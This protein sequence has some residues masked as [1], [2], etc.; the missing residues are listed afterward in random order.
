MTL[1][2]AAF[3]QEV[4]ESEK[5]LSEPPFLQI[6]PQQLPHL[7]LIRLTLQTL[8]QLCCCCLDTSKS[9]WWWGTQNW[10]Q[11]LG[12]GLTSARSGGQSL[13]WP[14]WPHYCCHRVE[15]KG[16]QLFAAWS[17]SGTFT[18]LFMVRTY[19]CISLAPTN[20]ARRVCLRSAQ[21]GLQFSFLSPCRYFIFPGGIPTTQG[22][23]CQQWQTPHPSHLASR[24][25]S[26]H[27]T[28][29]QEFLLPKK[30]IFKVA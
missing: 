5:V 24:K 13:P 20:Q 17:F 15:A 6:E 4:L 11:D 27:L 30:K 23:F 9:F 2:A 3:C 22:T 21:L 29:F 26:Q 19:S 10:T 16:S 7:L 8:P 25:L 18:V 12:Y 14:W 1:L 28:W